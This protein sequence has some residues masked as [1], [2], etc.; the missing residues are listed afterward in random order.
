MTSRN[1]KYFL[2]FPSP[3]PIKTL[4]ITK[5]LSKSL[6]PLKT[7]T[8]FMNDPHYLYSRNLIFSIT[9]QGLKWPE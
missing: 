2:A 5:A 6:D 9:L 4:F 3:L 7:V 8:S 1:F